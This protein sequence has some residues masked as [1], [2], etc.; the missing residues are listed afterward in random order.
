MPIVGYEDTKEMSQTTGG[1]NDLQKCGGLL[2]ES[3]PAKNVEVFVHR[4][5][6]FSR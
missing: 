6:A 3:T 1:T 2:F 5:D 4:F